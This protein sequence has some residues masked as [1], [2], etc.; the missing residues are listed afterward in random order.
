MKEEFNIVIPK[1][2]LWLSLRP[3]YAVFI[4]A[5]IITL[6]SIGT[7]Y[8]MRLA[9]RLPHTSLLL[10]LMLKYLQKMKNVVFGKNNQKTI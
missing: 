6:Y 4:Q 8:Q 5:R 3:R 2:L 10:S 7:Y 9:E 1:T